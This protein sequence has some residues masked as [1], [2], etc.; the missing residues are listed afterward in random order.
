MPLRLGADVGQWSMLCSW[1]A[2]RCPRGF[3]YKPAGYPLHDQNGD[4]KGES[5]FQLFSAVLGSSHLEMS[6]PRQQ[7]CPPVAPVLVSPPA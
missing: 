7:L 4:Y 1:G 2:A 5:L 3:V 6:I